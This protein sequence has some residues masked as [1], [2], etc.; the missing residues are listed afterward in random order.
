MVASVEALED[1][2]RRRDLLVDEETL[3]DFYSKKIPEHICS[4][5]SFKKWWKKQSS[6]D[7]SILNFDPK[8]LIKKDTGHL[9]KLSFPESFRQHNLTLGLSYHFDPKD[10]DDGVSLIVPLALLNQVTDEGLDW[11]IPGLRHELIVALIKALP[12]S[13]RRN[14]VPAPNY[15]DACLQD[16]QQIDKKGVHIPFLSSLST[17]LK[18]MTGCEIEPQQWPIDKLAKHLRFN[19]KIVDEKQK[20]IAQGRDLNLLQQ[21]LQGKVKDNLKQ[22]ATPELEKSGLINWDIETLP[23]EF[24]NHS[25][26]YEIK[27]YPALVNEGKTVGVK[28]FDQPHLAQMEHQKGIRQLV[29]L[30]IPSPVKYLQDKL[31]N[32]AKLGLYFN[33]FGQIKALIDDCINAG[34]DSL[35]AQYCQQ[36]QTDIRNK[37][38]FEKCSEFVRQEINDCVLVIAQQVEVGLTIAHQVNKKLKG[39]VPLNLIYA[40]GHIKAQLDSLV[41]KGFVADVGAKKLADWQRYIKAISKRLE[42]LALDPTKDKLHQLNLEKAQQAYQ[43]KCHQIPANQP[44]PKEL[45]EVRWMLQELQVSFFAQQ[46]GTSTPISVKRVLNHLDSI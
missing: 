2:S 24:V 38:Q 46:L 6:E 10:E 23:K 1:K 7:A 18:R 33:P 8:A 42:K 31:P 3:I 14:F 35:I 30:T 11:L 40:Q 4:E 34:V 25:G 26:G 13:L 29:I 21:K 17:K 44:I 43:A 9:D 19:I 15:A 28:L 32:K 39:N 41:Y 22:A 27:A 37:S 20:V 45:Q 12:K 16:M 5:V 36:H